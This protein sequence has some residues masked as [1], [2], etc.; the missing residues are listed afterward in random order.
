MKKL[1]S[2][3]LLAFAFGLT[4]VGA[5]TAN[6]QSR[7]DIRKAR[8]EYRKDVRE[9]RR[10]YRKDLRDGDNWRDARRDYRDDVRDARRDYRRDTGRRVNQGNWNRGRTDNTWNRGRYNKSRYYSNGR[11]YYRNN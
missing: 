4:F 6:A 11:W 10:D 8:K 5:D 9:A 3:T 1:F 2:L 7:K